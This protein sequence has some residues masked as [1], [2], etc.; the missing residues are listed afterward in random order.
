MSTCPLRQSARRQQQGYEYKWVM[1]PLQQ[2][3]PARESI[4]RTAAQC[5]GF[6][7]TIQY[8]TQQ[9]LSCTRQGLVLY[10]GN[11]PKLHSPAETAVKTDSATL[12]DNDCVVHVHART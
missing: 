7:H 8:T 2:A 12:T 10:K 6:E 3:R 5:L 4:N 11:G 1:P 9:L